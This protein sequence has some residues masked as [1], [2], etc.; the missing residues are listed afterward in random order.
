MRTAASV[1]L[2]LEDGRVLGITKG[3]DTSDITF[4]GGRSEAQDPSAAH[5]A[6][7]ELREETG[8]VV[9]PE[10][11]VPLVQ[12]G[13]HT[14]FYATEV[15]SWPDQLSSKPFEGFVGLW[16]AEAFVGPGCRY[17]EQQAHAMQMVGVM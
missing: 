9:R 16:P 12:N 3:L 14:T 11:L 15:E 4:P 7:R 10:S 13:I 2:P 8:V 1:L 5:T 17:A 6:A